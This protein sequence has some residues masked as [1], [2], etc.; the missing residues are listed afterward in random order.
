MS[1]TLFLKT[2]F[3]SYISTFF[4]A[5]NIHNS[6]KFKQI[7]QIWYCVKQDNIPGEYVE[8]GVFKGKSLY[9]SWKCAKKLKLKDITFY[10]LDSFEGFPVEN[11]NF[12][13]KE[14]FHTSY[15]KVEKTFKNKENVR[16]VKGFF[17]KTL[18]L[19]E[20]QKIKKIS[21]AFI[22][23]DIYESAIPIFEYLNE[24]VSV[25]GFVMIDDFSSVDENRN[26]IYKAWTENGYINKNFIFFS[27]YSNGQ[28]FRKIS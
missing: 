15:H 11:H 20:M 16:L 23:C 6:L 2:Y 4:S 17:D 10:G 12:Y 8:F 22:D 3:L 24:R 7:F 19:E 26:S 13:I 9:H 25:G 1:F 14:N 21:F 27:N 28:V 18:N 5:T